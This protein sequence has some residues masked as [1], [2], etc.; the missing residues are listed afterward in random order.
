MPRFTQLCE[1]FGTLNVHISLCQRTRRLGRPTAPMRHVYNAIR[2]PTSP[3]D[4][5]VISQYHPAGNNISGVI[6]PENPPNIVY[7]SYPRSFNDMYGSLLFY[8]SA[9]I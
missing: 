6:M 1:I 8:R 7:G 9:N 3:A 2:M 4:I 5:A